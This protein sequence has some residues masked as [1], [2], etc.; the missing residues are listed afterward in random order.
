MTHLPIVIAVIVEL[1]SIPDC[2]KPNKARGYC[3][4]HWWRWKKHGDPNGGRTTRG[5]PLT[6]FH[7]VVLHYD[8]DDCLTWPFAKAR[9]GYGQVR[10]EGRAVNVHRLVCERIHGLAP[11]PDHQAA[12]SCGRGHLGCVSPSHVSWKTPAENTADKLVHGRHMYGERVPKAKLSVADVVQIRALSKTI[13]VSELSK[14]FGVSSPTI[15]SVKSGKSW[16]QV[17]MEDAR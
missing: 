7:D 12:H 9:D 15:Y 4:G 16:V 8:G 13:K 5:A 10:F 2:G 11:T 3:N 1:C 6:Y 17:P 14:M